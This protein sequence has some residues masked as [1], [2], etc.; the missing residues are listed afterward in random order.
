MHSRS[1]CRVAIIAMAIER[2]R[3]TLLFNDPVACRVKVPTEC[4]GD[5]AAT[6]RTNTD[7]TVT[8][9]PPRNFTRVIQS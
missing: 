4:T 3:L 8:D 2:I 7:G 9:L 1:W 5:A 6:H